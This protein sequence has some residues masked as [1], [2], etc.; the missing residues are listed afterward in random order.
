MSTTS[1]PV[2]SR[3]VEILKKHFAADTIVDVSPSGVRDN[4]HV[5]VVSGDLDKMTEIQKQEHL[6]GLLEDAVKQSSLDSAD[7]NRIS[8][9]LPVSVE[10]LKR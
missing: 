6:W 5:L 4:L 3:I 7:L 2:P 9:V 1:D 8:L 10:E